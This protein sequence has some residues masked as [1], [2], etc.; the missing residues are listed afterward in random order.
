MEYESLTE[1]EKFSFQEN[2][3]DNFSKWR[4][5][6]LGLDVLIHG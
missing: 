2:A 3:F 1:I 6:P 4:H 5:F